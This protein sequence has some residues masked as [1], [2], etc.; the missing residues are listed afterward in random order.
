MWTLASGPTVPLVA[1]PLLHERVCDLTGGAK[2]LLTWVAAFRT[3]VP[4]FVR[5]DESHDQSAKSVF[6][7]AF[8]WILFARWLRRIERA[9]HVDG[10]DHNSRH[11]SGRHIN[12]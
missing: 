8:D 7:G 1:W 6:S 9:N 2:T 3:V 11:I 5:G 10:H 12:G 4:A